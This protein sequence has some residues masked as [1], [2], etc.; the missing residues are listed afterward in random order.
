[1]QALGVKMQVLRSNVTMQRNLRT[2]L[3]SEELV[4]LLNKLEANG[5]IIG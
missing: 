3:M 4:T 5:T 2:E 1:M